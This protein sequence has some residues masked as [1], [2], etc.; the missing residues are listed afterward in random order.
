MHLLSSGF[1]TTL[2]AWID[3]PQVFSGLLG[4]AITG[5]VSLLVSAYVGRR[6]LG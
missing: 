6:R 3:T 1:L 5:V 4:A 2:T